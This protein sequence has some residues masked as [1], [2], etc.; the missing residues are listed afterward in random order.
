[1]PEPAL[2]R[3]LRVVVVVDDDEAIRLM[4]ARAL[5]DEGYDVATA[6]DGAEALAVVRERR[7]AAI[8]LDY[9]MPVCDGATFAA[10]YRA[11]ETV[12]APIVLITAGGDPA[13]RAA[14]VQASDV[15][16]KPFDLNELVSVVG[17]CVGVPACG[18][19]SGGWGERSGSW[20]SSSTRPLMRMAES[21]MRPRRSISFSGGRVPR[22]ALRARVSARPRMAVMGLR[23]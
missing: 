16:P 13:E 20:W 1:M 14:A 2:G 4:V 15:L 5:R 21:R 18:G 3:T 12:P 9:Q 17:R 22:S 7:P 10:E 19:Y 8:V 6:R 23:S 11:A